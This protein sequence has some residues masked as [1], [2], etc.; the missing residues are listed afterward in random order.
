MS[1]NQRF[2]WFSDL[3]SHNNDRLRRKQLVKRNILESLAL[4]GVLIRYTPLAHYPKKGN[5]PQNRKSFTKTVNPPLTN[6]RVLVV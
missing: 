4:K 6:G 2:R 1:Q 3:E 5:I